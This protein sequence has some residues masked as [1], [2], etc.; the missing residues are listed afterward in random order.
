MSALDEVSETTEKND[1]QAAAVLASIAVIV[2]F[3]VY[4]ASEIQAVRAMLELAYG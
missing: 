4:W 3:V 2:G 1:R